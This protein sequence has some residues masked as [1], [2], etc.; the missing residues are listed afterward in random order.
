MKI[1]KLPLWVC[2]LAGLTA[3]NLAA[4][5]ISG[6][7]S[8][9]GN[10]T[11]TANT[12]SWANT[13][14][15]FTAQQ[16]NI[17]DNATGSFASPINLDGTLVTIEDLNATTEP[18]GSTFGPDE[19]I[20]FNAAPSMPTLLIDFIYAGVFT[21]TACTATP[22]VGQTCTPPGP[23]G[24][25]SPFSFTNVPGNQGVPPIESDATFT[26]G[27]ITSD[28]GIWEGQFSADF[29]VPFQTVLANLATTG[30]VTNETYSAEITVSAAPATTTPEP[31]PGAMLG[32]GLGLILLSLASRRPRG[33]QHQQ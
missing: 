24:G 27:G 6:S 20:S 5:G 7:F 25:A 10:I 2:V 13:N 22:A 8:I 32:S 19:F 9:D 16:S 26:F 30:S 3:A 1:Q 11:V 23:N 17:G 21:S 31:G 4:S 28:G 15:P 14:S 12:I 29:D 33:K 18:V